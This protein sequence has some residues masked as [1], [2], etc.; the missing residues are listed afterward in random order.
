MP[1]SPEQIP[2]TPRRFIILRALTLV[3]AA[4][5]AFAS[6]VLPLALRPTALPL[7]VGDVAPRALQAPYAVEF[8]SEVRTESARQ[9]AALTV[10][11]VYT[12]ADPSIA[13]AQIEDLRG[14]TVPA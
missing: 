10:A 11:P 14:V 3:I 5:A 6:L 7:A 1:N 13:R 4:S 9:T 8:L 2:R 12:L